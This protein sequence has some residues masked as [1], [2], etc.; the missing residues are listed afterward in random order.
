MLNGPGALGGD[1][2]SVTL[3]GADGGRVELSN[4]TKREV[5][6]EIVALLGGAKR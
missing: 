2:T 3:L 5:A 4:R 1:R 6:G